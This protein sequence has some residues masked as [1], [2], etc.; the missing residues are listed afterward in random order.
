M[1]SN[2]LRRIL[3]QVEELFPY[4]KEFKGA[5]GFTLNRQS[6]LV[7][8]QILL[9]DKDRDKLVFMPATFDEEGEEINLE[10]LEKVRKQIIEMG[11]SFD[12]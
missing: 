2:D 4:P 7:V 11:Y 12:E 5:H 10:T 3:R 9:K 8:L 6:G 1:H